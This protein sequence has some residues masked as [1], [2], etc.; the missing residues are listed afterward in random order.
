[1]SL[2]NS[3][4]ENPQELLSDIFR[5]LNN[6]NVINSLIGAGVIESNTFLNV[7]LNLINSLYEGLFNEQNPNS[8]ISIQNKTGFNKTNYFAFISQTID[9][10]FKST[11]LQYFRNP[12]GEIFIRNMYD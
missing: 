7:D 3:I 9:S 8:L 10:A 12:Q 5:L 6:D 4:R 1:L 11:Y 2:I